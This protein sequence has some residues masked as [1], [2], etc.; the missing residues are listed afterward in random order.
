MVDPE[1]IE[2]MTSA[3]RAL[4]EPISIPWKSR[5][6]PGKAVHIQ[7]DGG[8]Q[9]KH[10]TGGFVIY[11]SNF[12]EVVRMGRY[13]GPSKTNNEAEMFALRDSL[14]ALA[15]LLPSRPD[16]RLPVRAFGDSQLIVRFA[17]RIYKKPTRHTTYW[18]LEDIKRLE[19]KIHKATAYRNIPRALNKIADDMADRAF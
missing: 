7:F 17:T 12:N 8:A 11:D 10:G 16:L 3:E 19:R 15:S 1:L 2:D 6:Q 4:R 13:Y 14:A 5:F 9:E 18:A